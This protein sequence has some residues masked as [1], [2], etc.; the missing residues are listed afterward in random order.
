MR[1]RFRINDVK[2][3]TPHR[4]TLAE[5]PVSEAMDAVRKAGL[6]P[7]MG[8][9]RGLGNPPIPFEN[10]ASF[11]E[12]FSS[13]L[14]GA[15]HC[16][17][18]SSSG[19]W[20]LDLGTRDAAMTVL[21]VY[22]GT[23]LVAALPWL[24]DRACDAIE[25]LVTNVGSEFLVGPVMQLEVSNFDFPSPR[26]PRHHPQLNPSSIVDAF[27][28]A[29]QLRFPGPGAAESKAVAARLAAAPLPKGV[30]RETRG[31][32]L[33]LRWVTG[34]EL[35]DAEILRARLSIRAQWLAQVLELPIVPGYNAFGDHEV[36]MLQ[37][38]AHPPLTFYSSSSAIGVKAVAFADGLS[39]AEE[40]LA[41]P[42]SWVRA[43][44]LADGTPI[45]S[46][47]LLV[48]S[49]PDAIA[50]YPRARVLGFEMVLYVSPDGHW[51]DPFPE[52]QW[53]QSDEGTGESH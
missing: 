17:L 40:V 29:Y 5:F 24:A 22:T 12:A 42:A 25:Q 18:D 7:E 13:N 48:P 1:I 44:Q 14:K 45:E 19:D 26:P 51:W 32:V 3:I 38:K 4:S 50:V 41:E 35:A 2:S 8:I 10:E 16:T 46:L 20:R 36:I 33:L 23:R 27:S 49:R 6:A 11:D 52:G 47:R 30:V 15:H 37:R 21:G 9:I 39:D 43:G 34:A 31:D 53:V 28:H